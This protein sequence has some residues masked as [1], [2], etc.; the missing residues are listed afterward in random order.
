M[1]DLLLRNA[2]VITMDP[3][4]R[5][6]EKGAVAVQDGKITFVGEDAEA[7]GMQ[8]K[9]VIDC[10]DHVVM[11]GFVD[12]HGHGGHSA[13]K[14]I[15]K[16]TSYW[17]PVMTH[18]YKNYITDEF[19]YY[20]G[21][22]SA[23]ERLHAGVTTG[24]CVLGSQPRCD[25]PVFALNNAKGYA[26]VGVKD[27]VCT[28]P[29][30]I[31]WP[32]RFSRWEDGKRVKKE[33]PYEQVL[34][35]LET[36]I[37]TLNHANNDRTLA[38]VAPFGVVTSVDPSAATPADRCVKLTEHDLRQAKEM[39]RIAA[40]YNT[41]IH[42]DAFGGMIHLAYQDKEHALLGPDV[43]LQHC[44]GLSFDE[45]QILAKTDTHVSF[46]P[47]MRQLEKRTP[48]IELL[49]MGATVAITTD[50]S[51]LSSGFD[52]FSVMQRAQNVMRSAMH[53]DY[54]LPSQKVLEMTTI[55]AAKCVGLEKEVGSLE[56]G[57]RA[58]IIAINM[59]K[60]HLMPRINVIDTIVCN[61][62]PGDVDL[63]LVDGVQELRDGKAVHVDERE[64][65][66][67]AE[68]EAMATAE[69]CPVLR[70]LA[71]PEQQHWGETKYYYNT[72]RFDME[73]NRK[74]GGHY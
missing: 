53:D 31:P 71:F 33:V 7:E 64:I 27:I 15:V 69:R 62:T 28:G 58:D 48:V 59:M 1:V 55:D 60:P 43:H 70:P 11:P 45:A 67:R 34:E 40:K 38:Y 18:T 20:E 72:V 68:E 39:R 44:T 63:V 37:S 51:M 2:F 52:M 4:R 5:V 29:C 46:A 36:V 61:A 8:A 14:S 66:L 57:K 32:H 35:S 19:W 6:I 9:E 65:M 24:V 56:V 25:D 30:S 50:G 47:G 12:A 16:D 42:T 22:L 3:A 54:Y 10:A 23:L 74:D 13:F 73:E 21:R 26:E 17:M 41:R 49:D